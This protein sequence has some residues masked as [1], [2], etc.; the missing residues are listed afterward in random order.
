MNWLLDD[1]REPDGAGMRR[2]RRNHSAK[3]KSKVALAA[4]RGD[5]TINQTIAF[6]FL[7][8]ARMVLDQYQRALR[9]LER[10]RAMAMPGTDTRLAVD[11]LL[12]EARACHRKLRV[13]LPRDAAALGGAGWRP[14]MTRGVQLFPCTARCSTL[15]N[16]QTDEGSSWR[17]G[18]QV[19]LR[20]R[21]H[22]LPS[23]SASSLR[24]CVRYVDNKSP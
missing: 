15:T 22:R 5:K 24:L 6:A 10:A 14:R 3:F 12:V 9:E 23:E 1:G 17:P 4:L 20:R 11:S 8:G 16:N 7:A 2:P 18:S 19:L 21:S 13:A